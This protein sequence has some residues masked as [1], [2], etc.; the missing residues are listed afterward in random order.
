MNA[1]NPSDEVRGRMAAVIAR[2]ETISQS[3][4]DLDRDEVIG[5]LVLVEHEIS[6]IRAV[7]GRLPKGEQP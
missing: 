6:H 2:L 1:G 3:T 4:G 7:V 5:A